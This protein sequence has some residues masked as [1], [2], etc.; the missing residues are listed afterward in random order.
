M[1]SSLLENLNAFCLSN[2]YLPEQ[3]Q[4]NIYKLQH[5]NFFICII[6]PKENKL[7]FVILH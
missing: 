1:Y 3:I 4:I 2:I 7:R 6:L 5:L